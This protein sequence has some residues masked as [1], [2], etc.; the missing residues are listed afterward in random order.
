MA[1][2]DKTTTTMAATPRAAPWVRITRD[3]SRATR[4]PGS[5]PSRHR[6]EATGAAD[7]GVETYDAVIVGASFAGL[8]A[9]S[10]L[11]GTGRVL[12]ADR[13]PVGVG[14]TSACGTLL[15]ALER[16][17][18]S[19]ALEQVRPEL[20]TN[21]AARRV[22]FDT[23]YPFATFDCRRMYEILAARLA[24]VEFAVAPFRAIETDGTLLLG[25]RRVGAEVVVDVSGWRKVVARALCVPPTDRARLSTGVESHHHGGCVLETRI[26][27]Q[28]FN[29]TAAPA[30]RLL[31]SEPVMLF[32]PA[33][34]SAGAST[35]ANPKTPSPA[36]PLEPRAQQTLPTETERTMATTT[37]PVCGMTIEQTAAAGSATYDGT[38]YYF[39]SPACQ[40]RFEADPAQFAAKGR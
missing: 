38:T 2:T 31:A 27:Q 4:T 5:S 23:A 13:E 6:L 39:C 25:D 18:A 35:G 19:D 22:G 26:D 21:V 10:Q 8:A 28:D 9:A 12:L 14:E 29:I 7:D 24:G 20:V 17:D 1:A 30:A 11:D 16:L 32:N 37:D 15:A 33:S 40:E 3:P 36:P 34:T